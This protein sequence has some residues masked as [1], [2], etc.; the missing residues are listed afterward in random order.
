MAKEWGPSNERGPETYIKAHVFRA[1]WKCPDCNGEYIYPINERE[2]GD[3]SCPYCK[4]RKALAGFNSLVDTH[5][6]LAKEWSSN[7]ERGPET[8]IK[9]QKVNVLWESLYYYRQNRTFST[10]QKSNKKVY[11]RIDMAEL[12][13]NVGR[14]FL[15]IL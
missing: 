1:L 6:E 11:D 5:P 8:Y 12:T 10:M 15:P 3:D 14:R 7:N 9:A 13:Y 4:Q 2:L